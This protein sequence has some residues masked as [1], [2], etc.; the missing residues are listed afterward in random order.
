MAKFSLKKA[1]AEA[2][3][4]PTSI[5]SG[6]HRVVITQ[7]AEIGLQRAFDKEDEPR[8]SIGLTFEN[9]EGQQITKTMILSMNTYSNFNKL[10]GAV[11]DVEELEDLQGKELDIE[12]E[13]N[14]HYPKIMSFYHT[15]DQMSEGAE[16]SDHS[17]LIF[18]SVDKTKPEVLKSLHPQLRQAIAS[19][20]RIKE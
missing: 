12:V 17:E 8:E 14:G 1:K 7:V 6:Y 3:A 11:D 10:L 4:E 18:Y 20:V 5:E 19:R 9:V 16:I 13:A 2:K 15:D